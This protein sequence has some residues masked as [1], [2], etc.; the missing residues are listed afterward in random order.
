MVQVY[1]PFWAVVHFHHNL[2]RNPSLSLQRNI[3]SFPVLLFICFKIFEQC[4]STF[5]A[6]LL[7]EEKDLSEVSFFKTLKPIS[8]AGVHHNWNPGHICSLHHVLVVQFD[9]QSKLK[10]AH[11]VIS[12]VSKIHSY[13]LHL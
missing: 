11:C 12:D 3:L 13:V 5:S 6:D 10:G 8:V 2:K 7:D 9:A 4:F 1:C